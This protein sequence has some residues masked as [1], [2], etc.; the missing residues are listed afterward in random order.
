MF[1]QRGDVLICD[2]ME[3]PGEYFVADAATHGILRGP[4]N[5]LQEAATVAIELA[6]GGTVWREHLDNRG[7]PL[8]PATPYPVSDV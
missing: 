8:G 4:F 7:R 3:R 5:S 6:K 2:V 1:P